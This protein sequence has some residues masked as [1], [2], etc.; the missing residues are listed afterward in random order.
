M[1]R[2]VIALLAL[3]LT[4]T[5]LLV[6][7]AA[8]TTTSPPRPPQPPSAY[9]QTANYTDGCSDWFLDSTSWQFNCSNTYGD[10]WYSWGT[11]DWFY[12]NAAQQNAIL[13][14]KS[15]WDSNDWFWWCPIVGACQA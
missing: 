6:A 3:A 10:E 15:G 4:A 5:A 2:R 8:A 14:A 7:P 13:Y 11:T 9:V 1:T 12:W